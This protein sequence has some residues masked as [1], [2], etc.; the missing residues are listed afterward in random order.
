MS[1]GGSTD[2]ETGSINI[3]D[4][5]FTD[6]ATGV[7]TAYD[8]TS[9]TGTA[10]GSLILENIVL[11]DT[12]VAVEGPDGT[13]L[14][15]GTLTIAGWGEGHEYT[16]DGPTAFEGTYTPATRP[17]SLVSGDKYYE[18]SKPSYASTSTAD[19][20][21]ARSAGAKGDGTTDDTA[22]LQAVITEGATD[23]KLVFIDAGTY[24]VSSTIL[25][26]AGSQIVGESYSVIMSSGDTFA[27]VS[28][29]IPVVQIGNPGDSGSVQWS[30]MIVSTQGSQPGAVLIEWNLAATSG[31]GMW[32]VHTRIGGFTGSDL[33]VADCPT[34]AAESS[35][36]MAAYMSMHITSTAS[37]VYMENNWLWTADHDLDSTDSTQISIYTGRGLYIEM[38]EG[39]GWL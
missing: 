17:S 39:T 27:D 20:L 30:D 38:T 11:T 9:S 12:P 36:C 28:T 18:M 5:T 32:D 7:K 3:I 16:P 29:P 14:T 15:G 6:T 10:N 25:I 31:S 13:V 1:A 23:G 19:V 26:P 2:Q 21:S 8:S 4:S 22:A 24:L 34:T 33:Q 37:G 35:T